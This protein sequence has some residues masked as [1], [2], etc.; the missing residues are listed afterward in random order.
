MKQIIKGRKNIYMQPAALKTLRKTMPN[1]AGWSDK[2]FQGGTKMF[3]TIAEN[4]Y[5]RIKFSGGQFFSWQVSEAV[6]F[7]EIK[8]FNYD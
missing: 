6:Q 5:S 8:P 7:I 1:M 4:F 2:I 3:N